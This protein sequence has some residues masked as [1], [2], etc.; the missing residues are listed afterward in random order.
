[1]ARPVRSLTAL[2][3]SVGVAVLV[4]ALPGSADAAGAETAVTIDAVTSEH[5]APGAENPG[6]TVTGT[7]DVTFT[8]HA[9]S[10]DEPY[11]AVVS[12]AGYGAGTGTVSRRIDLAPGDCLPSCT[13]HAALDTAATKPFPGAESVAAPLVQDGDNDIHVE[14]LTARPS[15]VMADA[16]VTVD[17]HL[18]VVTLPDLPGDDAWTGNEPVGLSADRELKVRAVAT[19][20]GGSGVS[21]VEFFSD[22]PAWPAPT[23]LADGG[24]GTWTGTVDTSKIYSALWTSQYVVAFDKEGHAGVPVRAYVLVDH[25]FTVTPAI[26]TVIRNLPSTV[27]VAY[28]YSGSL[29][30]PFPRNL[31]YA[32]PVSTR[33]LLDG[34]VLA[35]TPV[36]DFT[37]KGYPDRLYARLG[38]KPLP[39]GEHTLTFDVTDNRGAHGTAEI[40]VVVVSGVDP[41]WVSGFG[42]F[43]V[44]GKTWKPQATTTA[45]DGVSR[46]QTWTMAV[47][48]KTIGTGSYPAQ[49]SGSWKADTPGLHEFTLTTVS[50]F[51][52]TSVTTEPLRVLAATTTKLGGPALTTYGARQALTATVTRTGD[53]PAA[54]AAVSLQFRPQGSTTWSTVAKA[55]ADSKGTARFTTTARRNGTWR[56]VTA[57]KK[58]TW[59]S[60]TSATVT[61]KV[62]AT[63]TVKSPATGVHRGKNVTYHAT[64]TPYV[65]GTKIH[66]QVRKS[67]GTWTTL[68]AARLNADGTAAGTLV[69]SR[70]G[71]YTV[72]AHRP[73]GTTLTDSYS[74]TWTVRV[75]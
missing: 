2:A 19:D 20:A 60:S 58:L 28:K 3:G 5:D 72:R 38:D 43:P 45:E 1:M 24:D 30:Q 10:D 35:T 47:D 55:T 25:G 9:D 27:T 42:E 16:D 37:Y 12:I 67:D 11:A 33:V 61:G 44:A 53:K 39:Y 46:A 34:H 29:A 71:T 68:T 48:G 4:V 49:P 50:Q 31:N 56:A 22:H 54:G 26:G 74:T 21:R 52:D 23:G 7:A 75:S 41:S 59:T 32:Y 6:R 14:V 69:F 62:K 65:S 70:A 36:T 15:T 17:N 18:P 64:S 57:E 40:P 66:F 13:L 8:V 73:A 63:L 51:G